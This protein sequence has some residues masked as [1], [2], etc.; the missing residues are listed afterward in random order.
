MCTICR[1]TSGRVKGRQ[2]RCEIDLALSEYPIKG[3]TVISKSQ[4]KTFNIIHKSLLITSLEFDPVEGLLYFAS[5]A[6]LL[7][8]TLN[9]QNKVRHLE[10][11]NRI[12]I[13][14]KHALLF[15]TTSKSEEIGV[16]SLYG[17]E[18]TTIYN[19][20]I[21]SPD[22]ISLDVDNRHIYWLNGMYG[23]IE[24]IVYDG[25]SRELIMTNSLASSIV[26]SHIDE[27]IYYSV[28]NTLNSCDR[29]GNDSAILWIGKSDVRIASVKSFQDN[30][31]FIFT[32]NNDTTLIK[33]FITEQKTETVFTLIDQNITD[34]AFLDSQLEDVDENNCTIN[35]GDCTYFCLPLPDGEKTCITP[36]GKKDIDFKPPDITLPPIET[37]TFIQEGTVPPDPN[38]GAVVGDGKS[39]CDKVRS[40]WRECTLL[41]VFLGLCK[42]LLK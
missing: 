10:D 16:M 34:V 4:P 14:S 23:D 6:G 24:R 17:F 32:A 13:D 3:I 2:I 41:L 1:T 37:T 20:N 33:Y 36:E 22:I 42:F 30:I 9:G 27:R 7:S 18:Y 38:V 8:S 26:Y 29:D 21:S 12:A 5:T 19:T 25:S 39:C 11:V 31:Y 35:F 15:Y 40:S 28:Q